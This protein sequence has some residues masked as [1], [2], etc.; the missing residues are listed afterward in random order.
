MIN[1]WWYGGSDTATASALFTGST[2]AATGHD[3]SRCGP[4]SVL[5]HATVPPNETVD[6]YDSLTGGSLLL[7]GDTSFNTPY[8]TVNTTYY[9]QARDTSFLC[10]ATLRTPVHAII[11]PSS[12]PHLT[13]PLQACA[14]SHGNQYMTEPGKLNYTW[15]ISPGNLITSGYFTNS[16]TVAWLVP[17]LQQVSVNYSD[18]G[19]CQ[20]ARPARLQVLVIPPPDTAGPISGPQE[21]CAGTYGLVYSL[22]PVPYATSYTWTL[23]AGVVIVSG[24][25]LASITVNFPLDAQSGIFTVYASDSCGDGA[26]AFYPVTVNQPSTSFAGPDDTICQGNPYRVEGAAANSYTSL[27]WTTNGQGTFMD[28][29]TLTPTYNPFAGETGPV[30][31]TLI[32]FGTSPCGNDTS[33]MTLMIAPSPHLIAGPDTSVCEGRSYPVSGMTASNYQSLLWTSSGSGQFSDPHILNPEYFPSAADYAGGQV[34]LTLHG[35]AIRPCNPAKDSLRLTFGKGPV[36]GAGPGEVTC[37]SF[38][39]LLSGAT[40]SN[41]DSLRWSSRGAGTLF[42]DRTLNP[43]YQPASSE[44]GNIVLTLKAYGNKACFDTLATAQTWLLIYSPVTANAGHDRFIP[45]G[46][47]DT[48]AGS[49]LGGSGSFHYTWEPAG[50]V[51]DN[52]SLNTVTESLEEDTNFILTITD[53]LSGCISVDTVRINILSKPFNEINCVKVYNVITPNGDGDNDTWI[54]DCIEYYPLNKVEIFNAWGDIVRTFSNYNNVSTVWDGTNN[55]GK[56]LPDGT[57]YYV[58]SIKDIKP[59]AGWVFLRG[60]W[61]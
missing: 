34:F 4:G 52:T 3:S 14:G 56:H 5:L 25:G 40:A 10:T 7:S 32:A 54:I 16:I 36:A 44:T 55:E 47:R 2:L 58:I 39:V 41:Y 60:G 59:F 26:P 19:S 31:L 21:I 24:A 57:Y 27:F 42:G 38:P 23:P 51:V 17:G 49:V 30:I 37:S 35:T 53:D 8:I 50:L 28:D 20:G 29:T 46:S 9:A 22:S 1:S 15:T 33:R 11:K 13:G 6:W 12:H 45:Y 18:S 43:S 61:R 48:L